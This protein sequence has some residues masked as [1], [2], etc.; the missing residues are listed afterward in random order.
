MDLGERLD[1]LAELKATEKDLKR[2][3]DDAKGERERWE[4]D[5][6]DLMRETQNLSVRRPKGSFSAKSTVYAAVNDPEAFMAWVREQGLEDE[7]L[8]TKEAKGRLNELVREKLDNKE[9]L[10]PGVQWYPDEYVSFTKS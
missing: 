1:R 3:Y 2:Q 6:Y 8:V 9:P 10:P 7:F 5:T 4:Q